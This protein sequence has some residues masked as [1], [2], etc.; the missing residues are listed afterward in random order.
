MGA[1]KRNQQECHSMSMNGV[2]FYIRYFL[3]V[4]S[5]ICQNEGSL[6]DGS[7]TCDCT[8]GFGGDSCECEYSMT[9]GVQ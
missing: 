8:D 4:C 1:T 6:D 7:C 5:R 3:S 2:I 9:V